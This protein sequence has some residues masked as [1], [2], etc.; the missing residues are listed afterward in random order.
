MASNPRIWH[1]A[2][3]MFYPPE[4]NSRLLIA[5]LMEGGTKEIR[6]DQHNP[7]IVAWFKLAGAAWIQNDEEAW[8]SAFACGMAHE[9]G[10][11]H[12][13]SVRARNWLSLERLS[14]RQAK[15]IDDLGDL[16]IGDIVVFKSG[17]G[18]HVGVLLHHMGNELSVF[19]GNQRNAV[20]PGDYPISQFLGGRRLYALTEAE[21][22]AR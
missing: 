7:K 8:C 6:G 20:R 5:S 15:V 2:D 14:V 12:P 4:T 21:L 1:A 22:A 11:H 17:R 19:G 3:R 18:H 16:M 13:K 10:L 9:A